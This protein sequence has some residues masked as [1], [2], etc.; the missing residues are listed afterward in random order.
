MVD[1]EDDITP[2]PRV[3]SM[4]TMGGSRLLCSTA[5]GECSLLERVCIRGSNKDL[6][7]TTE[8]DRGQIGIAAIEIETETG[9]A[10]IVV[11]GEAAVAAGTFHPQIDT[12]VTVILLLAATRAVKGSDSTELLIHAAM[13]HQ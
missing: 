9:I 12:A 11:V 5:K 2:S 4:F 1:S 3:G 8:M 6:E 13:V 10:E 7:M